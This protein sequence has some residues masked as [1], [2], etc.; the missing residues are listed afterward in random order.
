[1]Y[2]PGMIQ[3]AGPLLRDNAWAAAFL[4]TRALRVDEESFAGP[5]GPARLVP[6][7][8]AAGPGPFYAEC[9]IPAERTDLAPVLAG[10]G[11]RL[12][13]TLLSFGK[14]LSSGAPAPADPRV[15]QAKPE[16]RAAV[17]R[18][19]GL[20]FD[21]NHFHRDP[22]IPRETARAMMAGWA[23]NFFAGERGDAML[24]AEEAGRIAGFCLVLVPEPHRAVIDLIAVDEAS[25]GRGLG[26]AMLLAAERCR[27]G[28]REMAIGTQA[29]NVPAVRLYE[30]VGYRFTRAAH[31]FHLHRPA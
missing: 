8:A 27:G 17:T 22:A 16:D 3:D 14:R 18:L 19:S 6:A 21:L 9:R 10:A 13:D 15:R 30:D 24:V 26:R 29:V 23:G 25:R 31:M 4:G 5:G 2:D 20:A 7:L 1:M 11:F 28:I 12:V